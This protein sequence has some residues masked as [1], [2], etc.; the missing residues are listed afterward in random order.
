[1]ALSAEEFRQELERVLTSQMFRNSEAV[2]RLLA[3][4]GERSLGGD[5]A[6]LK[7]FTIGVEA[8]H[9]P[10]DYNPQ[11]DP[12]VRVLA[13]KLRHK[14]Q[15]YY[16]TEGADHPVQIEL[17]KGHYLLKF[18]VRQPSRAGTSAGRLRRW[19]WAS[20]ALAAALVVALV[21]AG[22]WRSALRERGANASYRAWSPELE[23]L[24]QPYLHGNRPILIALGTP[25]FTK[26]AGGFFR[27]PRL[28]EWEEAERSD[29]VRIVQKALESPYASPWFNFTGIGEA[30]GAFL[31]CKLLLLRKADLLLKRSTA[32]TWEDIGTHNVIFLGSPK[33]NPKLKDIPFEQ[34]FVLEGGSLRN[35]RPH[36]GEPQEFAE[37]W[38]PSHSTLLEDHALITRLPGL[39]GHGEITILA[40]SSTEGTWAATE[41]VTRPQQARDLVAKLRLAS[42]KM[43]EAYQV[44]IRAK[45]K[46]QVPIETSYVTHRVLETPT[47]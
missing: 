21:A 18:G 13:S 46:D 37:V 15:D 34:D 10:S 1:M 25:L 28:N 9:K 20:A 47:R 22:Q 29:R 11:E 6:G 32:V 30:N 27:D 39:H 3:Y 12:T 44:V 36:R 7:E 17:P 26:V 31:L 24:W 8:F 4:L 38:T 2:S 33:F 35:R 16:Q 42:G 14:L 43:P 40:A 5:G 19:Q 41:Y 45:Y 23:L